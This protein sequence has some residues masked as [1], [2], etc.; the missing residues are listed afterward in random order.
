MTAD[1]GAAITIVEL[2]F[3]AITASVGPSWQA[4]SLTAHPEATRTGLSQ[5]RGAQGH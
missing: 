5:A 2:V 1:R 3:S 4:A